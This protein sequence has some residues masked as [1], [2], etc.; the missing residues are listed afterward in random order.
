G[1][2]ARI[3]VD[4]DQASALVFDLKVSNQHL[5]V[6]PLFG[7]EAMEKSDW[8]LTRRPRFGEDYWASEASSSVLGLLFV[9]VE[10]EETD[11]AALNFLMR[12]ADLM[13]V[14]AAGAIRSERLRSTVSK[15]QRELQWCES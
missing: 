6:L 12:F 15:L 11:T 9:G 13:G 5:L 8:S 4:E 14:V 2:A 7:Q 1:W 3:S 10:G